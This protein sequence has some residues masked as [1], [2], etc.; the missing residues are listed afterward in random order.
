MTFGEFVKQRRIAM[1]MSLRAFTEA[2]GY[3]PGNHSKLERGILNPPDDEHW[4]TK[5][6]DALQ[7]SADS[8]ERLEFYDLASIARRE[9]PKPLLDDTEVAEK[10]PV[11][12]R[13]LQGER[14]SADKMD[15]LVDFIRS[16]Q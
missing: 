2:H 4:M 1:R 16:R 14:L 8:S 5:M 11:L 15:E 10:L 7:L 3:D 6:A 12:F 9:I 13:T